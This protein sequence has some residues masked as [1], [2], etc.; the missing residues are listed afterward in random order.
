MPAMLKHARCG[1]CGHRHH[2]YL[3]LGELAAGRRYE[4]V[5]P[6]TG[7]WA[8]LWPEA[9]GEAVSSPTQGVVVLAP[10]PSVG[11]VVKSTR[12]SR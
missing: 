4:Y 8:Y 7:K 12:P 6:E 11:G 5:C 10:A 3:A 9:D 1:A 2:F